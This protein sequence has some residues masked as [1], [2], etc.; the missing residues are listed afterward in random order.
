[1]FFI[2]YGTREDEPRQRFPYVTL[3]LAL[4][5]VGVFIYEMYL[6]GTGGD[7]ALERFINNYAL[8]PKDV[9]DG[10][11]LAI[12]LL[13]S[14]FLHGGWLH[15][16]GNMVYFLPFGDN[17]EDRLGHIRYLIFYIVCGVFA[18][19]VFALLNPNS[20]TPL[21]GAS[22]AIAGVL[23][24][25]LALHRHAIVKGFLFII[26]LFIRV[27]LP[28]YLFIGYWFVLQVFSSV[29]SLGVNAA[30]GGGVAFV[31]HVAGFIVGFI[32]A[33]LLAL[34]PGRERVEYN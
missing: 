26:I 29:A 22:G 1:M 20:T 5:C 12:G 15:I 6:M 4:V 31:A 23:G 7:A 16:I 10:S 28:A 14:M 27:D 18:T 24:G 25:Y 33:P 30:E 34:S 11:P 9:T 13:S 3:A 19:A 17:V 2:P 32:L 21:L 8:T